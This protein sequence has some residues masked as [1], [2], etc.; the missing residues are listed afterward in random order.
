MSSEKEELKQGS[1]DQTPD[2][3]GLEKKQESAEQQTEA[4]SGEQEGNQQSNKQDS[5]ESGD[6][7]ADD[8]EDSK[9]SGDTSS[10]EDKAVPELPQLKLPIVKDLKSNLEVLQEVFKDCSDFVFREI[11]RE[12]YPDVCLSY[13][14]GIVISLEVQDHI[15]L[16]LVRGVDLA[17]IQGASEDIELEKVPISLSHVKKAKTW[18][19]AADGVTDGC[20]LVLVEENDEALLFDLKGG[21]RRSVQEPQTE[22]VVRGPREGFTEMIRANTGLIRF[23]LKTPMLK[24]ENFTLGTETKTSVVLAYIKGI[25]R[26]DLIDDVRQRIKKINIDGVL[27]SGYIEEL[28]EDHPYSPFPQLHYTERPDTVVANLLEGRFCI[29]VDGTPFALLGPVTMWQMLQASEDYYERFFISNFLRWIRLFFMMVALF[30]PALY[31][32][33]TTFHQDM[34]PTTLIIS[35]AAAREAIPFPALVEALLMEISFEAL[36]EAGVRLPKAVGQAVSILGALVIGQAAVTAGIVS[37][38]MV[39]IV[40]MTGIASFTIPRF[41]FAITLRLLRFPIMVLAGTLGLFG[42]VIG[43]VLISAHLTQLTSFGQPYLLGVSPYR[44]GET[45]DIIMRVPWWKMIFKPSSTPN[46]ERKRMNEGM[47][48][49][50]NSDEGW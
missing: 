10:N 28:I 2:N 47:N 30:L 26:D 19:E 32:A 18:R 35:I 34:L 48:G 4:S 5:K 1:E 46:H 50:P 17:N 23:K 41:N 29:L 7:D 38:P 43:T 16:P 25:A 45:K 11:K 39:I 40:S 33:I 44:K 37:A 6:S 9:P 15:I 8:Q 24:M 31:I 27:E 36:R 20:V 14:E 21:L 49:S 22:G 3:Q 42:I 13:L 12:G